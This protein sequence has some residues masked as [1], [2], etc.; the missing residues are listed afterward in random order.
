MSNRYTY[1]KN[2]EPAIYE[3]ACECRADQGARRV[4]KPNDTLNMDRS[5]GNFNWNTTR[6][7]SSF[8]IDINIGRYDV[9][10]DRYPIERNIN[11]Y[12]I[13]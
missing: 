2:Y 10:Y 6:E 1:L 12:S 9:F 11:N 8:W 3:R 4:P 5:E 13:I 7:G